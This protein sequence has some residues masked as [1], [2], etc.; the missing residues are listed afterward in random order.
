MKAADWLTFSPWIIVPAV[1]LTLS[2]CSN[3]TDVTTEAS[4]ALR[5]KVQNAKLVRVCHD[6]T[7]IGRTAVGELVALKTLDSYNGRPIAEIDAA[8]S[9]ETVCPS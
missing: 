7:W 2:S 6:G 9:L 8:T 1:V 4:D 3:T 5:L